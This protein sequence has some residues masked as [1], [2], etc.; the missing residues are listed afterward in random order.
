MEASSLP[1]IGKLIM[2]LLS[3]CGMPTEKENLWIDII[4][5]HGVAE[6]M[7]IK[8]TE[9]G[10]S[11]YESDQ[12]GAEKLMEIHRGDSP[13]SFEVPLADQKIDLKEMFP[14]YDFADIGRVKSLELK[15]TEGATVI[16]KRSG[17]V[18]YVTSPDEA[19]LSI[20]K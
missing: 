19:T 12:E 7:F 16:L 9:K 3:L 6:T 1:T 11:L 2:L 15:S 18:F 17:T 5:D 10:F 4:T 20:H 8:P 13:T 14:A